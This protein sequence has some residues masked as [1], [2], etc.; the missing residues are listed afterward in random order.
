MLIKC[1]KAIYASAVYVQ[2]MP[3]APAHEYLITR[4]FIQKLQTN[5]SIDLIFR[6]FWKRLFMRKFLVLS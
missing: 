2:N 4:E 6:R 3:N 5:Y 1:T